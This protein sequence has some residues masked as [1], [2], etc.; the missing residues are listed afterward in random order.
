[1]PDTYRYV[2][3]PDA[4]SIHARYRSKQ[5]ILTVPDAYSIHDDTRRYTTIQADTWGSCSCGRMF[6]DFFLSGVQMLGS[7]VRHYRCTNGKDVYHPCILMYS[8]PIAG[9]LH[10]YVLTSDFLRG[11]ST[12]FRALFC[13]GRPL[14]HRCS[15]HRRSTRAHSAGDWRGLGRRRARFSDA[16]HRL[17]LHMPRRHASFPRKHA[18]HD[19]FTTPF[20][21]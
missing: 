9:P 11:R 13:R 10:F 2:T 12:C 7:R 19:Y 20:H 18:R 21:P 15:A 1:M 16:P 14:R 8:L 5:S 17:A 3:V 6:F 4:H